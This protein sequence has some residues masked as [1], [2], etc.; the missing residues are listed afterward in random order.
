MKYK[1]LI[2]FFVQLLFSGTT[3]RRISHNQCGLEALSI[4]NGLIP[5]DTGEVMGMKGCFRMKEGDPLKDT[6]TE[7]QSWL[8]NCHFM[9]ATV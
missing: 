5:G 2:C 4:G 9:K 7:G 3:D 1:Y 8:Y 6:Q